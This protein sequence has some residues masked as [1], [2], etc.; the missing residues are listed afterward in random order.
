MVNP[1]RGVLLR[2]GGGSTYCA[3]YTIQQYAAQVNEQSPLPGTSEDTP[4]TA[5]ERVRDGSRRVPG[6]PGV[7]F[8]FEILPEPSGTYTVVQSSGW[9]S[10]NGNNWTVRRR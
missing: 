10:G 6:Q 1:D 9:V 3:A 4:D 7:R 5:A 8:A 2:W